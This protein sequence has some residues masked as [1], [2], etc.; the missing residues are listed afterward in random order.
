MLQKSGSGLSGNAAGRTTYP[1]STPRLRAE[2][3][4][5]IMLAQIS[6][7][8]LKQQKKHVGLVP[9]RNFSVPRL[10][11]PLE[12]PGRT[13]GSSDPERPR[14]LLRPWGPLKISRVSAGRRTPPWAC[15][16]EDVD[17]LLIPMRSSWQGRLE[18]HFKASHQGGRIS[19][20]ALI[21][22]LEEEGRTLEDVDASSRKTHPPPL[23]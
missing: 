4:G 5:L 21:Q 13:Q 12:R 15:G 7:Q 20:T 17:Y 1:L 8:D 3:F 19:G 6:P 14:Q 18:G 2:Q 22:F 23:F 11:H 16:W 9:H 10:P